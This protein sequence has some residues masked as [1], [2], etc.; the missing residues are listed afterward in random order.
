[1]SKSILFLLFAIPILL[2][3]A[4]KSHSHKSQSAVAVILDD[5]SR[6]IN[7]PEIE[8]VNAQL[9]YK[10]EKTGLEIPLRIS[11]LKV[12]V[13]VHANRATTTL[14]IVFVNELDRILEGK[15]MFPLGE[16]QTISRF[17]L[18][19]DGKLR[20]A[21]VIEK[22]KGQEVYEATIRQNIDPGLLEH[23]Q[24]NSYQARVYPIPA[25]GTKRLIIAY[26]QELVLSENDWLYLIPL[27][28]PDKL[29]QFDLGVKV[30][31]Q[32]EKP[33]NKENELSN[34]KFEKWESNYVA[35]MHEK[36]FYANKQ[37]GFI[38]P[39]TSNKF[40]LQIGKKGDN[41]YFYAVVQPKK[42]TNLKA[43]PALTTLL[44]DVSMSM[45][46]R[47]VK[48]ELE[49]LDTY[50]KSIKNNTVNLVCFS[51]EIHSIKTFQIVNSNWT[52]LR[53][54]LEKLNY[55]GA[56]NL[57]ALDL[58]KIPGEEFILFSDGMTNLGSDQLL[59]ENKIVNCVNSSKVANY[60]L[61]SH[62]A[63]ISGGNYIN[64]TTQSIAEAYQQLISVPLRFIRA[65]YDAIRVSETYPSLSTPVNNLF[66]FAGK[67]SDNS[68]PVTLHFGYGNRIT[69]SIQINLNAMALKYDDQLEK[70]WAWKKFEE[71]ERVYTEE[72]EECIAHAKEFSLVTPYTSLIVLDRLEDYVTHK[73]VPPV[74]LQ[75]DYWTAIESNKNS[76]LKSKEEHLNTVVETYKN[77]IAWWEKEYKVVEKKKEDQKLN[78]DGAG[79]SVTDSTVA[80]G[81]T[82]AVQ[83]ENI[84][85]VQFSSA[86]ELNVTVNGLIQTTTGGTP[87]WNFGDGNLKK[88]MES[89]KGKIELSKWNP[90]VPYIKELKKVGH[91]AA[92]DKYLSM[93][94]EYRSTPAYFLDVSDYFLEINKKEIALRIL[95]NLVEMEIQSYKLMRVLAHRYEQL[96]E[97]EK[98]V[99]IYKKVA[100][101]RPEEPQSY[102]DL[103]LALAINKKYQESIEMLYK[104]VEKSWDGRF[105]EIEAFVMAELNAVIAKSPTP[106]N[107]Q[108]I[109]K[110]LQKH[111]P[112]DVRVVVTWDSDN[113]DM[114]LWVT[115]PRG[116][117]CFYSHPLTEIGGRISRDFTGGYGP[118][119]FLIRKAY[120]GKYKVQINYYG[121]S[122]Q[123]ITGATTIQVKLITNYGKPNEKV[124]EVTRRLSDK[125]EVL[126]IGEF[127]Y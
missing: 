104:V 75:K 32:A 48:R 64:L 19:I 61:L 68:K 79:V 49:L 14:D 59:Y 33:V 126:D 92:Y 5:S 15:M 44:W 55:D 115:D 9:K 119:E 109:D 41:N 26:E 121:T 71:L 16:G 17:A 107:T 54:T 62:I 110:R 51:N 87:G 3:S 42:T 21:V 38:V 72:K 111:L 52:E 73:I 6:Q 77:L 11:K 45:E 46:Q 10:D 120:P 105:P 36:N 95:S 106:L 97:I 27:S 37:L 96:G 53:T 31:N 39:Q 29:D 66:S 30:Y 22:E 86:R 102:R 113:C 67:F 116:E 127:I 100:K 118:E 90:D 82:M 28:F 8:K 40:S 34:L 56:T 78:L 125:S 122:E 43:I 23:V 88:E 93:R 76:E 98:A 80:L 57:D 117:K 2:L 103:G 7:I 35:E 81:S 94:K 1:M 50:F 114:D 69:E 74:E 89:T 63:S 83:F 123:S 91:E 58:S 13:D 99:D 108:F 18:E 12:D 24:G 25:K 101:L 84:N 124:Q 65:D 112:T 70:I 20:E 4:G 47:D 85:E 60:N